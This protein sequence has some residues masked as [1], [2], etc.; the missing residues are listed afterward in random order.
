M[1]KIYRFQCLLRTVKKSLILCYKI[2]VVFMS[3]YPAI[4][5]KF[6]LLVT[7]IVIITNIIPR[8]LSSDPTM[9]TS[10]QINAAVSN[11]LLFMRDRDRETWWPNG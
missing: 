2:S 5:I 7:L 1:G 11:S 4:S 6:G 3:L 9:L 10:N 8:P